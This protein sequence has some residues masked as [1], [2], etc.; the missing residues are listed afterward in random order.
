MMHIEIDSVDV[1]EKSG[2]NKAGNSYKSRSQEAL[3]RGPRECKVFELR[4]EDGQSPY[5]LGKYQLSSRSLT[6]DNYGRLSVGR[7]MLEPMKA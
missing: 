5:P 4:L 6:V 3:L 7:V 1:K 2:V